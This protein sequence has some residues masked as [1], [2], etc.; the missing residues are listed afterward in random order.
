MPRQKRSRR[1]S[2]T[3]S[4]VY[5]GKGQNK[6]MYLRTRVWDPETGQY[7]DKLTRI[8]AKSE[9]TA[10]A[11]ADQE[12]I[13][14]NGPVAVTAA[15]MTFAQA[16]V[17]YEKAR[18]IP[19][20]YVGDRKVAGLR[21]LDTPKRSLQTLIAHFGDRRLRSITYEDI[22][23]FKLERL[24]TPI[25]ITRKRK[26][27]KRLKEPETEERPR[28]LRS[29]HMEL[30]TMRAVLRFAIGKGWLLRHPFSAGPPLIN[31]ADEV[32]RERILDD[33]EE[34]RLLAACVDERAHLRPIIICAID[35][36]MRRGEMFQVRR[37]DVDFEA[38]LLHIHRKTTKTM[39]PKIIGL[40]PRLK[41][42]LERLWPQR[43]D[44]PDAKVFGLTTIKRSFATACRLAGITGLRLHDLR[45]TFTT[46]ALEAGMPKPIVQKLTGHTS[47]AI[48]IYTRI[49]ERIAREVAA[50]VASR[51]EARQVKQKA[52]ADALGERLGELKRKGANK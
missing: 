36:G 2:G 34:M 39:K 5:R 27:G 43:P 12:E 3:G 17:E 38:G 11:Q 22:Q 9:A 32:K 29:V 42:E 14:T 45:A 21:S 31:K 28:S 26:D 24:S 40:T 6:R 52:E 51:N 16:A 7:R 46:R 18:L 33:E 44:D 50:S 4:I 35:T 41:A 8:Y 30:E 19:A 1:P 13:K 48:D 49:N 10:Q 15:R 25:T 47:D 23:Q 20:R 37:R